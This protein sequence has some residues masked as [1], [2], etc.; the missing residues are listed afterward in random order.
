[1]SDPITKGKEALYLSQH[2]LLNEILDAIDS[3]CVHRIRTCDSED[4]LEARS[5]LD[6]VTFFRRAL[7]AHLDNAMIAV[8]KE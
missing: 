8:A 4:L 5:R 2:P 7:Q 1:M 6:G 3:E